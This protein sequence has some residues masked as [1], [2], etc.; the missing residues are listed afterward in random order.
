MTATRA[1]MPRPTQPSGR[2]TSGPSPASAQA[3]RDH[4]G[5]PAFSPQPSPATAGPVR[6][7]NWAALGLG[8]A[9]EAAGRN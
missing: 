8:S 6:Q 3:E 7:P 1:R 2:A 9:N 4:G 5:G